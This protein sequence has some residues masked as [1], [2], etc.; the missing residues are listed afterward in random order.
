MKDFFI[1]YNSAD[2]AWA[3]WIAWTLEEAGY[4]VVI[5][6][7]DFRPGGDFILE[8]HKAATGTEKTVIVLSDAYLGAEYTQ[9]EWSAAFARDPR[10][11]DR[12]LIPLRV[13]EC[14]PEGLLRTR[15]YADLVALAAD[16]AKAV[17]LSALKDRDKPD[18][19]PA[20]PG[21]ARAAASGISAAAAPA[22]GDA[23]VAPTSEVGGPSG[24]YP[25]K[26]VATSGS[27]ALALWREKLDFL[28]EQEAIA[29]D[30]AQKFALIK[31]IEEAERKVPE[32][33]G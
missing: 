11:D 22:E 23:G 16:D 9:P 20:F 28:R 24:S 10:G 31:Q 19:P 30:P 8:M 17:L 25:G 32:L 5:Q 12:T 27:K 15:I 33:G 21:G 2:R 6:A 14:S 1:S 18:R 26:P 4:S 13:E 3:E 7:W 29:A